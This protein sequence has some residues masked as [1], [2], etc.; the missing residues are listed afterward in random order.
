MT[1]CL[2]GRRR[3]RN[4]PDFRGLCDSGPNAPIDHIAP[5][6]L[7]TGSLSDFPLVA[8]APVPVGEIERPLGVEWTLAY[9]VL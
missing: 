6:I 9:E 1:R 5:R 2:V 3:A 8:L 7:G 4:D